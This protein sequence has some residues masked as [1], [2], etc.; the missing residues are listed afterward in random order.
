MSASR[1][2]SLPP[3]PHYGGRVP[4]EFC[5]ISGAQNLSDTLN[6]R[7]ATSSSRI[8]YPSL[9]PDGQSSLT[10]SLLLSN[11]NPLRWALRWGPPSAACLGGKFQLVRFNF[12]AWLC[13]ANASGA[14]PSGRPKGLPYPNLNP[15]QSCRRGGSQTRPPSPEPHLSPTR[16]KGALLE[17]PQ[18]GRRRRPPTQSPAQRV[19][20]G[21]E[22]H[23][24]PKGLPYPNLDPVQS[25]RR[26]GSQTRPPSP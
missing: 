26:G 20:V 19:C 1:S 13:R 24:R 14:N 16:P 3:G 2:Y 8:S 22:E 11:A 23:G 17:Y 21:K 5:R 7:R 9:R 25:C 18:L 15:V 12:Y 10:P 6:S 4:V